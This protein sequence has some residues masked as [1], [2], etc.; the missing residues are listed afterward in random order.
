MLLPYV[1]QNVKVF[2]CPEGFNR[3]AGSSTKGDRFQLAYGYNGI[4]DGPAGRRLTDITNG[5][6]TSRVML[7]WEHSNMPVCYTTVGSRRV[8]I[9]WGDTESEKHYPLRHF[10]LFN[11]LWCDGHAE[12]LRQADLQPGLFVISE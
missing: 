7:V 4:T 10:G 12:A 9:A 5:N 8:P 11:V 3:V 2:T 1:E 6:G